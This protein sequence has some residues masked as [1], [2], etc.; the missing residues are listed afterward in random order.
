MQE[1]ECVAIA[2]DVGGTSVKSGLVSASGAVIGEPLHTPVA[3]DRDAETILATF[4]GV[5]RHHL[6]ALGEAALC[7]VGF[8]FPDPMEYPAGV[9][10]IRGL[11]KYDAL[12]GVHVGQAMRERVPLGD[13]VPVLFRNDAEA[14][15]VGEALYG[16]GRPYHRLIGITLGTGLGSAFVIDGV[17]QTSGPGVPAENNG[18]LYHLPVQGKRADDVFSIRGLTARLQA[19]GVTAGT[20]RGAAD[21]ARAGDAIAQQVF[22]QFGA[23]LGAFLKP[24]VAAFGAEAVLVLGGIAG[25]FDLFGPALQA[26]LPVRAHTTALGGNAALLGAAALVL[27]RY[28]RA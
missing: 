6:A 25:A 20:I 8:G 22:A 2:L 7:G 28:D 4:A 5:V 9:C 12:Y 3:S 27:P 1:S 17:R 10:W 21:A 18:F 16:A 11:N 19:A 14:A 23:D 26:A 15:V 24:H 13:D